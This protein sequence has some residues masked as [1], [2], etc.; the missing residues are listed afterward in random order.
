MASTDLQI[1]RLGEEFN[2]LHQL[3]KILGFS[4]MKCTSREISFYHDPVDFFVE[5]NLKESY[6]ELPS[7]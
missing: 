2:R 1:Q 5:T 4:N 3:M 6:I 7:K